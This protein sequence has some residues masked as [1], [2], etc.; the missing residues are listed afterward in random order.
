MVP[1]AESFCDEVRTTLGPLAREAGLEGPEVSSLEYLPTASY[2]QGA[3]RYDI[4][5]DPSEGQLVSTV[6][7]T[8]ERSVLTA[9]L[10]QVAIAAGITE[11]RG[12]I[13]FSARNLRQLRNSLLGHAQYI[14]LLHPRLVGGG[15]EEVMRR[16]DASE[17]FP[18]R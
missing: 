12:R 5:L 4:S 18:G 11:A 6:T 10:E 13:S 9:E 7:A 2:K 15:S 3:V 14:S 16:A 17:S 8:L 1:S